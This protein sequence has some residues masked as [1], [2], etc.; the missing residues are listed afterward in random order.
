MCEMQR[1]MSRSYLLCNPRIHGGTFVRR[2]VLLDRLCLVITGEFFRGRVHESS[3]VQCVLRLGAHLSFSRGVD[4]HARL[5]V[6]V[7]S[8]DCDE[9]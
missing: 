4:V 5:C 3:F 1:Y 9:R 7:L 6:R 8:S 2:L